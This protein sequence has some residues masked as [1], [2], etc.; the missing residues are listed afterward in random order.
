MCSAPCRLLAVRSS[1][2]THGYTTIEPQTTVEVMATEGWTVSIDGA[3]AN[4]L[5]ACAGGSVRYT[6]DT[7][8]QEHSY[9][10]SDY[11]EQSDTQLPIRIGR[12]MFNHR[13]VRLLRIHT[14]PDERPFGQF[15]P[16]VWNLNL[17]TVVPRTRPPSNRQEE[18]RRCIAFGSAHKPAVQDLCRFHHTGRP[19]PENPYCLPDRPKR[20]SNTTSKEPKAHQKHQNAHIDQP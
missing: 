13:N 18:I 17:A 19:Q 9:R 3:E 20:R 16:G 15:P 11:P 2:P 10:S 14:N 12:P 7:K 4:E 6:G 5:T 1:V 8:H